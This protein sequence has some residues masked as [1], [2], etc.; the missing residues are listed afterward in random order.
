[1]L[2]SR[3]SLHEVSYLSEVTS[4]LAT[5]MF[6]DLSPPAGASWHEVACS[7][8]TT[9]PQ[10]GCQYAAPPGGRSAALVLLG[11]VQAVT[12]GDTAGTD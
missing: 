6:P 7:Y 12:V 11:H 1:M 10:T 8:I 2:A 3:Y 9:L 5:R 4:L